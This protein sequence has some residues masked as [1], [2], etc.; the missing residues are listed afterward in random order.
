MSFREV[1]F[2]LIGAAGFTLIELLIALAIIASLA[3]IALIQI[4][5]YRTR[6]FDARA[7]NDLKNA[8]TAE[9]AFFSD[10]EH[11]ND[12]SNAGCNNPGL[13]GFKISPDISIQCAQQAGGAEFQCSATHPQASTTFYYTSGTN[14]YW[15]FP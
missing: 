10:W 14:S 5:E 13:P 15:T 7:Q 4:S 12:C 6:A 9:E 2:R 1:K 8:I 3:A 11:Y